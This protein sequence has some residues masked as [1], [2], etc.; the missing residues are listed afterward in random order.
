MDFYL[1]EIRLMS[2]P[3]A[4]KGWAYCQGQ[5]LPVL[6]NQALFSLLGTTY[7]GD[8]KN[9]FGL[10]DLRGRVIVGIGAGPGLSPIN[11]GEQGGQEGVPLAVS[12]IPPHTHTFSGTLGTG[13]AAGDTSPNGNFPAKGPAPLFS[14]STPGSPLNPGTLKGQLGNAGA[15]QPHE[16]RQPTLVMN[17][18]IALVGLFPSRS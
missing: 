16:N 4:P 6:Q 8:G 11:W 2:F 18:A 7:G 3:A 14:P 13:D 9:T 17:Y 10:P 15:S 1:G 5:L 12:Q